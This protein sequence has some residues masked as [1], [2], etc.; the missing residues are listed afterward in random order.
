VYLLFILLRLL[1]KSYTAG[2]SLAVFGKKNTNTEKKTDF[3]KRSASM[4]EIIEMP[5]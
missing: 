1:I 5:P 2:V 3:D 4:L